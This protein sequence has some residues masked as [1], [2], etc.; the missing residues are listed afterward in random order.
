LSRPGNFQVHDQGHGGGSLIIHTDGADAEPKDSPVMRGRDDFSGAGTVLD[1]RG[2]RCPHIVLRA[3]RALRDL[4]VGGVLVLECTDPL[5]VVDVPH[6]ANQTGH[7]L[8]MQERP[9]PLY[10][11]RIAKRK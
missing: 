6:F 2:V 5:S 1:L 4:P 11:F 9:G 8:E 7:A 3:K 10:L